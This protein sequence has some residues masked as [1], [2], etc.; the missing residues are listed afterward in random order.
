MRF[1]FF[2]PLPPGLLGVL[3]TCGI[4]V[5]V[6]GGDW[7]RGKGAGEASRRGGFL[8]DAV[9]SDGELGPPR[10]H[11]E[12]CSQKVPLGMG[13][14]LKPCDQGWPTADSGPRR[15]TPQWTQELCSPRLLN[16][17]ATN[18][19]GSSLWCASRMAW[20]RDGVLCLF[21]TLWAEFLI[22]VLVK[23]KFLNAGSIGENRGPA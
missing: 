19:L 15:T 9:T 22:L 14:S 10:P 2:F 23:E 5:L 4:R 17:G 21:S 16:L 20:P 6:A 12:F 3:L 11:T 1:R 8:G 18:L 13:T 7:R